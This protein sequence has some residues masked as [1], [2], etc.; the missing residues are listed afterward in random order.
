MLSQG[1]G[2]EGE[3]GLSKFR[4]QSGNGTPDCPWAE[5]RRVQ[6]G[7]LGESSWTSGYRVAMG[8]PLDCHNQ[9]VALLSFL[10]FWDKM[11]QAMRFPGTLVPRKSLGRGPSGNLALEVQECA[12]EAV[13]TVFCVVMKAW[14]RG[15]GRWGPLRQRGDIQRLRVR[16]CCRAQPRV[17]A[18]TAPAHNIP[19]RPETEPWPA[20]LLHSTWAHKL[21]LAPRKDASLPHELIPHST[22]GGAGSRGRSAPGSR[23][24]VSLVCV[25]GGAGLLI[26]QN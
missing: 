21:C 1:G 7:G 6:E 8:G 14:P 9:S 5:V 15:Q 17:Q 19:V 18:L 25:W 13:P 20:G 12:G 22:H 11:T 16:L 3:A 26:P 4:H 10:L 23:W 24:G 2:A